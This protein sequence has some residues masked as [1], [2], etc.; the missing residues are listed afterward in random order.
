MNTINIEQ[1]KNVES[2][3]RVIT[4][5][6]DFS[7]ILKDNNITD[8]SQDNIKIIDNWNN[9]IFQIDWEN[10]F[11]ITTKHILINYINN[12]YVDLKGNKIIDYYKVVE[13]DLNNTRKLIITEATTKET[14]ALAQEILDKQEID[15][16][17]AENPTQNRQ[18]IG[19]LRAFYKEVLETVKEHTSRKWKKEYK[20]TKTEL[21]NRGSIRIKAEQNLDVLEKLSELNTKSRKKLEE[22][23]NNKTTLSS[24]D[25]ILKIME[26]AEK[27]DELIV[28]H[29]RTDLEI[30]KLITWDSN[31]I[32]LYNIDLNRI[33]PKQAKQLLKL[34]KRYNKWQ[35]EATAISAW[36]V[37]GQMVWKD[38]AWLENYLQTISK[39]RKATFQL[40]YQDQ[41]NELN[42]TMGSANAYLDNADTST[43]AWA[44]TNRRNSTTNLENQRT[45]GVLTQEEINNMSPQE[46]RIYNSMLE[47]NSKW[48]A[49]GA[50]DHRTKNYQDHSPRWQQFYKS[51]GNVALLAG[52]IFLGAKFIKSAWRIITGKAAKDENDNSWA[53]ILWTSW[54]LLATAGRPQD[55]FKWWYASEKLSDFFQWI[56]LGKTKK[57]A[58]TAT[59]ANITAPIAAP[60]VPTWTETLA[61]NTI[62]AVALF[63]W[64]TYWSM[65]EMLDQTWEWN[66]K[67]IKIK[68][69]QY[70]IMM[71]Q[72]DAILDSDSR[73]T[74]GQKE[75]AQL[76]KAF[77]KQIWPKDETGF[78]NT[79][80]TWI[81]LNRDTLNNSDNE[82][83]KFD[84]EFEKRFERILNLTEYMQKNGIENMNA[85][86]TEAVQEHIKDWNK[87]LDEIF[88]TRYELI[89]SREQQIT[90]N[91]I[92]TS[93]SKDKLANMSDDEFNSRVKTEKAKLDDTQRWG[94]EQEWALDI[95]VEEIDQKPIKLRI[96]KEA[97]KLNFNG[98]WE[99]DKKSKTHFTNMLYN[100]VKEQTNTE[101]EIINIFNYLKYKK[102]IKRKGRI[103]YWDPDRFPSGSEANKTK[104]K[105]RNKQIS[106]TIQEY[107]KRQPTERENRK[108]FIEKIQNNNIK[109]K[110]KEI[111]SLNRISKTDLE[112]ELVYQEEWW[113]LRSSFLY[114]IKNNNIYMYQKWHDRYSTWYRKYNRELNRYE[115]LKEDEINSIWNNIDIKNYNL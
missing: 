6:S 30:N 73:A 35:Q 96:T 53:R 62:W 112:N 38:L 108:I 22:M 25:P 74:K 17:T 20:Y 97:D 114:K 45:S 32:S 9:Y 101:Q 61:K 83:T 82:D 79:V 107:L 58:K 89:K 54:L 42:R 16:L 24:I 15:K 40:E 12:Y 48:W 100:I 77:L 19:I 3:L 11:Q 76:Q 63:N 7:R 113:Q 31:V 78:V 70:T 56:G 80:L 92:T 59:T 64:Q 94:W 81:W 65:K 21:L 105:E 5:Y 41:L 28:E 87:S 99:F 27:L 103:N 110:I 66:D 75:K 84:E 49:F 29:N 60:T 18:K 91:K 71:N 8:L 90:N 14:M 68:Q 26:V 4:D 33:D 36:V 46:R 69:D 43:R 1:N 44:N 86:E 50:L 37:G 34:I 23:E 52:W 106:D 111:Y 55:L 13:F 88:K 98:T 109:D 93:I 57:T 115:T 72:L 47:A 104:E 102:I 95:D 10:L 51:F 67:K 39:G 85:T 2:D